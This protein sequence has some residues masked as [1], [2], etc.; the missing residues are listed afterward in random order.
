MK[1]FHLFEEYYQSWIKR[2]VEEIRISDS[3]ELYVDSEASTQ[4]ESEV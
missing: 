3:K 4:V 1:R 2:L